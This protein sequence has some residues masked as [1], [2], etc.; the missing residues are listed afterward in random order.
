MS[1]RLL[2]N[3]FVPM[4]LQSEITSL[5][6]HSNH[7]RSLG[8]KFLISMQILTTFVHGSISNFYHVAEFSYSHNS[9]TCSETH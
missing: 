2:I 6:W 9:L 8:M 7:K 5:N 1:R 3:D 4:K